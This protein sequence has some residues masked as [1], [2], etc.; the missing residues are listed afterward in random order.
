M[1]CPSCGRDLSGTPNFCAY[2]GTSLR[3]AGPEEATTELPRER[4]AARAATAPRLVGC[5]RCA[6]PNSPARVLCGRCGADLRTGRDAARRSALPD[7][8][9]YVVPP[10]RPRRGRLLTAVALAVALVAGAVVGTSAAVGLGPFERG[11]PAAAPTFDPAAFP[12]EP[13]S[14]ETTSPTPGAV[15]GDPSTAWRGPSASASEEPSLRVDLADAAWVARLVVT[16]GDQSSPSA[17]RE[18]ARAARVLVRFDDGPAF[19]IDLADD[20]V[21]QV[22][23]L[24]EP[25]LADG[26]TLRVLDVH[27]GAGEE[28]VAIS[29]VEVVG[30]VAGDVSG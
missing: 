20:P 18:H 22:V 29:D 17:Y 27:P 8:D 3:A 21:P 9:G 6:A 7:V 4:V 15:D 23:A 24:P 14:L 10:P 13:A 2:C 28:E 16:N 5:P 25:V 12:G 26:I 1:R 19:E 11:E 30:W